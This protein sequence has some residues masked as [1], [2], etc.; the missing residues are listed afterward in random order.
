KYI[1]RY[2]CA[3]DDVDGNDH[4]H[5]TGD[6][7]Y[8]SSHYDHRVRRKTTDQPA[9]LLDFAQVHDNRGNP[10]DVV[11]IRSQLAGEFVLGGKIQH[12]T[13]G[14]DVGLDHHDPPGTM[15]HAQRN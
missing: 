6:G 5:K 9:H 12:R 2:S 10:H 8:M 1:S 11:T 15:K 4:G 13:R 14:G 7:S 3:S